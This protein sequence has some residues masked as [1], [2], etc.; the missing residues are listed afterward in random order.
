MNAIKIPGNL[1]SGHLGQYHL[2]RVGKKVRLLVRR[3][4]GMWAGISVRRRR[5][6]RELSFRLAWESAGREGVS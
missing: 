3:D 4:S 5:S 2:V 6:F 1:T